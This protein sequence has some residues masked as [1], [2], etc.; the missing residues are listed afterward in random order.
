MEEYSKEEDRAG[1]PIITLIRVLT[2]ILAGVVEEIHLLHQLLD[3]LEVPHREE[4][5]FN[6]IFHSKN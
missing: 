5:G 3:L 2:T 6:F 1:A 4:V